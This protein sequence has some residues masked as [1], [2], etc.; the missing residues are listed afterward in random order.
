MADHGTRTRYNEGCTDGPEGKACDPCRKANRDYFKKYGQDKKSEKIGTVT[1][2]KPAKEAG[3]TP[4]EWPIG[5]TEQGVIAVLTN[6]PAAEK[7]PD[8]VASARAMARLQDNPLYAAQQTAAAKQLQLIMDQLLKGS[9]K[10][11][12][13]AAVRQM[14]QPQS[15]TG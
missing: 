12:R 3:N 10:K 2:L 9:E 7:R 5:P 4:A 1:K 13:L 8:L 15:A 11:G 6:V 14:S